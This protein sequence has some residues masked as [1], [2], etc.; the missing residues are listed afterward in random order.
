MKHLILCLTLL[1]HCT[2][3]AAAGNAV[4]TEQLD[5]ILDKRDTYVE[6]KVKRLDNI[7]AE[8]N[9]A[10]SARQRLHIYN[11]LYAEYL[12][13]CFDSTM[14]YVEKASALAESMNDYALN[15]ECKIHRAQALATTGHFSQAAEQL[16]DINS[17]LLPESVKAEY[18][19]VCV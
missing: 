4:S 2:S 12:T 8:L 14:T 7:K 3:F 11:R 1:I 5:A 19:K 13:L 9:R 16:S 17:S 6:Q 18:Y 15:A 10:I